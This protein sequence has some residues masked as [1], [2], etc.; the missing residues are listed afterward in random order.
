MRER[1]YVPLAEARALLAGALQV[2]LVQRDQ[3]LQFDASRPQFA[4][5]DIAGA[6]RDLLR[7]VRDGY[8]VFVV[9]RHEGEAERATYPAAQPAAP[10]W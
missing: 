4:A 6:E 10:R 1:L 7:L 3:P 5:R 8:R 2:D 9:F